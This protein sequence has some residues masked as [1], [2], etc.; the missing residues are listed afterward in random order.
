[1]NEF[2]AF[3]EPDEASSGGVIAFTG[4][5]REYLP[6]ALSNLALTVVTLGIYRFWAKAR[7][8]RYLWSRT[9]FVDD[10]LEWTGTGKEMLVGFLVVM[11]VLLPFLIFLQFG[12]QAL[13]LRGHGYWAAGI[14]ALLYVGFFYLYNVAA[15]RSL[16]Y[17]LSRTWWH[18]IR[19][20]SDEPGWRY[21]GEAMWRIAVGA[22][23]LG[24][25]MPWAKARL[26]DRRWNSMSFGPHSFQA[27]TE[28]E[29]LMG[30]W[31]LIYLAPVAA[32]FIIGAM[33]LAGFGLGRAAG[34]NDEAA[35]VGMGVAIVVG[36]LLSYLFYQVLSFSF[37]A[38]FYRKV[39]D[40]TKIADIS[41]AFTASTRDWVRLYLGHVALVIVT[42]GFGL[43]FIAYRNWSFYV[44]HLEAYGHLD[45]ETLVQSERQAPGD[46]EGLAEAFDFGAV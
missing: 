40:A 22:G 3:S 12:L 8:R 37:Y 21:G 41:F 14:T 9:H 10:T 43:M 2:S 44:R 20:G 45:F 26:W 39:A 30:R 24:M 4:M 36:L 19:G 31:L 16:R 34:A 1:M 27:K 29:G 28:F 7:E 35:N 13:V 5:W 38:L 25:L 23:A 32:V 42:L 6:I 11:A 17:R 18:G 15:F 46:A 33:M